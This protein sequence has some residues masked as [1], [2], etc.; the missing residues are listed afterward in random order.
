M[1]VLVAHNAVGGDASEADRDVLVQVDAVASALGELGHEVAIQPVDLNLAEMVARLSAVAPDV[2]FNLVESLAGFDGLQTLPVVVFAALGLPCTGTPAE[3]LALSNDKPRAKL[4]L[5]RL[6]LPT[7]DW[8]E[9]D[10]PETPG[11]TPAAQSHTP[12]AAG[13]LIKACRE[14]ASLA[15]NDDALLRDVQPEAIRCE[16]ARRRRETGRPWFAERYID[17]REFNVSL[18]EDRSGP[19]VLPIAEIDFSAFEEDRLRIVS[20]R[21]KWDADSFE[22][23]ATPRRFDFCDDDRPLRERLTEMALRC[24]RGFGLRGY[25]RVDF[26]VDSAGEP[27]ILEIN[28]NPCLSPDAG[29]AAAVQRAGI[30][31]SGAIS[32]IV[33][34]ACPA[35]LSSATASPAQYPQGDRLAVGGTPGGHIPE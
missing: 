33:E 23:H 15:L 14:H 7:P 9:A 10:G 28:A 24:W 35:H 30:A 18:L 25:A 16:L 1:R 8:L 19:Q 27:W 31:F 26:R 5:R 22:Y 11:I 4:H 21:A 17:G 12:P 6:G 32:R 2:V 3:A 29:F 20:Y 34:S 13:Y